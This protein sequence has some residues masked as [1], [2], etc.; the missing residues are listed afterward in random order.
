MKSRDND[1]KPV[2]YGN[3]DDVKKKTSNS[4]EIRE[5][6]IKKTENF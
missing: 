4:N 5:S 2:G 6:D 3:W 1:L